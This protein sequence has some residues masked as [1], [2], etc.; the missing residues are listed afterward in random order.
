MA[1]QVMIIADT[2][3]NSLLVRT[4]PQNYD[5]IHM[6][7]EELDRPVSQ[8]LIKVLI[9]EVTHEDGLDLG[10]ELS[11]LN[12]RANGLGQ[13]YGSNFNV[14]VEGASATGIVVQVL[15]EDFSAAIR[16]LETDGKLDVLSRPYILASDNQVASITVGQEVPFI[17]NSRV[18]DEGGIINT[19]TYDDIGILLDVI[20]HINP[21]GLVIL[22]VAPEISTLTGTTVPI[23]EL[24]NAPVIAK[25]SALSRVAVKNG[26]TIVI[27][28][29]MEDRKTQTINKVP[30]LGDIPLVGNLF[31]R[32]QTNKVK[33]ELL[34]FLTPHVASDPEMLDEMRDDE[35]DGTHLVP[36]AVSPG[37]Y[38]RHM[39]GLQRGNTTELKPTTRP[40]DITTL[41]SFPTTP[42]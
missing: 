28:G 3:T 25:R 2:D 19:I 34:I 30:I 9:A 29:L 12:L 23:S 15:E 37:A 31:K 21:D 10:A 33:T 41:P 17:T 8:V 16:A 11:I 32:T 14:P 1:G 4:N 42:T 27:G 39:Q 7:L 40:L 20:P 18:T 24:V 26:Q 22:D 13:T 38:E 5:Q 36:D 6:V 35:I